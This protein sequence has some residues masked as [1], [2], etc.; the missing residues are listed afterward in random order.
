MPHPRQSCILAVAV[1]LAGCT[2]GP[3]YA[4]RTPAQLGVPDRFSVAADSSRRDDLTRW[5]AG[6]DDPLLTRLVEQAGRDNLD[7]AQAV[8]RLRQAR[9][10]LVQARAD[11]FPSLSTSGGYSRRQAIRGGSQQTQLPDGTI[12]NTGQ[13]S[14]NNFSLGADVNYQVDLF[15]GIRRNVEAARATADGSAYDY[16]S[17]LISI[18]AETARNYMLARAAQAQLAN[19]RA[20][21]TIQDDNLE[22]AGFRVQA[23]LVSSL[24][25]EAARAQRAQT[26]ASIPTIE[27]SY[28]SAV[29]RIGVLTGQAPGALKAEMEAAR[30]IPRGAAIVAT[31]LPAELIRQRPDVLSAERALAA[32][33]ARIGVSEAQLYPALSIS[34]GLDTAASAIGGLGEIITGT[35]FAG[36]N[37][38]LFDGGRRRAQ[39]R[40]AEAAADAAFAAYKGTVLGALEEVENALVALQTAQAR[41]R[42][43]AT[44]LDAATLSASLAR[45]QYRSG[46]TDFTT[47][48]QQESAL[49]SARNSLTQATSDRAT[50]LVQLYLALGGGWDSSRVPVAPPTHSPRQDR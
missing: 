42:E 18:Q 4:P 20:S 37:Q 16:A 46:L 17:V 13:G 49:V 47:L 43:L 12:I 29:S 8:A 31:G 9:E 35:L 15:G 32:A 21:L 23:G 33:T 1:A 25:R 39:V 44:A 48:N 36:L 22:I 27:A 26:A 45:L 28:N 2:A 11:F 40:S 41:E 14:T 38:I 19:A 3:D 34:G 6:F 5:W 30:P 50:A 10:A 24:D 7:V